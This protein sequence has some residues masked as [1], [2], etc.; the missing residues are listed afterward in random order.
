MVA[1][2]TGS[3]LF[4]ARSQAGAGCQS[5]AQSESVARIPDGHGEISAFVASRRHPGTG[6]MIRDSGKP[7]SLYSLRIANGRPVVREV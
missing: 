2:L 5:P 4:P 6:W 1:F 7:A 3:L